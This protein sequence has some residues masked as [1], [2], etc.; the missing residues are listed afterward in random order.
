MVMKRYFVNSFSFMYFCDECC[1][2]RR[3]VHKG[4]IRL[5]D[6]AYYAYDAGAFTDINDGE[7]PPSWE[8]HD[9]NILTEFLVGYSDYGYCNMCRYCNGN[10]SINQKK[11]VV[12]QQ[13]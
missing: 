7:L 13:K 1:C 10:T 2:I 4:K 3:M 5:C 12:A 6:Y 9:K 11:I 8:K